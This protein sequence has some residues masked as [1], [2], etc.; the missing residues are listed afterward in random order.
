MESPEAIKMFLPLSRE[1]AT[2]DPFLALTS[3][4]GLQEPAGN[5]WLKG[6]PSKKNIQPGAKGIWMSRVC[7]Q[8]MES[9]GFDPDVLNRKGKVIRDLAIERGWDQDKFDGFDQPLLDRV[10]GF[11]HHQMM[12]LRASIGVFLGMRCFQ[13]SRPHRLSIQGRSLNSRRGKCVV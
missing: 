9:L 5:G 4:L 2:T 12:H 8:L 3:G 7:Y 10:S 11:L 6:E 1:V 13:R